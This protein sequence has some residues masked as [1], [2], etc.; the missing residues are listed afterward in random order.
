MAFGTFKSH[1]VNALDGELPFKASHSYD[2]E[3]RVFADRIYSKKHTEHPFPSAAPASSLPV[4]DVSDLSSG[5]DAVSRQT[6][7]QGD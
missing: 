2:R 5:Q 3:K 4:V 6:A 1:F 7:H